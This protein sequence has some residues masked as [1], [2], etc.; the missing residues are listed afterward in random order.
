MG[1]SLVAKGDHGIDLG[2]MTGRETQR[3]PK[4]RGERRI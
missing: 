3:T 4:E 2:G 1:W